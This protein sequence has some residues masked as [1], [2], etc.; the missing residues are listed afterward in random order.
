MYSYCVVCLYSI[1]SVPFVCIM[2]LP[3]ADFPVSSIPVFSYHRWKKEDEEQE[4][5]L[6]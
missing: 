5:T 4:G 3:H 6:S 1:H 2:F